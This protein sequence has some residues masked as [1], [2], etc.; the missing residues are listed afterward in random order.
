MS[1]KDITEI[2]QLKKRIDVMES[3]LR[4]LRADDSH[5]DT[6]DLQ[7]SKHRERIAYH[8]RQISI[9]EANSKAR[10]ERIEDVARGISDAKRKLAYLQNSSVIKRMQMLQRELNSL[11]REIEDEEQQD[12][13]EF[14]LSRSDQEGD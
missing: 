3:Y 4:T 2:K 8:E 12:D 11:E 1:T 14:E 7:I 10:P 5:P 6:V 9:I 13:I